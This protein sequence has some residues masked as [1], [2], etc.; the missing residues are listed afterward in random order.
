MY[1]SFASLVVVCTRPERRHK[2]TGAIFWSAAAF[3]WR[4]KIFPQIS[5]NHLSRETAK[6]TTDFESIEVR[7]ERIH[8]KKNRSESS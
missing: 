4:E 3:D 6:K 5:V 7:I 8:R 2:R 1:T